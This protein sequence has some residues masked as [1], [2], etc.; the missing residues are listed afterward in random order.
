MF[1]CLSQLTNYEL[2][3]HVKW[4]PKTLLRKKTMGFY[5]S[6]VSSGRSNEP[7][8]T[9]GTWKQSEVDSRRSD[10]RHPLLTSQWANCLTTSS[11]PPFLY[12]KV[13]HSPLF[14]LFI[15]FCGCL[16]DE[17]LSIA[18][19]R[20]QKGILRNILCLYLLVSLLSEVSL[21]CGTWSSQLCVSDSF[22]FI[23]SKR[24]SKWHEP[25]YRDIWEP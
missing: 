15:R 11:P 22:P 9:V 12:F 19:V 14:S 10:P 17:Q 7:C 2:L 21:T 20:D 25:H 13:S 3:C 24:E 18:M 23:L 1:P 8:L 6:P 16:A 5:E 4:F